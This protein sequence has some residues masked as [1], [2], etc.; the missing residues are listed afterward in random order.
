[1]NTK[2]YLDRDIKPLREQYRREHP[3]MAINAVYA[4]TRAAHFSTEL[5]GQA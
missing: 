4:R 3:H 2:E 5:G 1:M